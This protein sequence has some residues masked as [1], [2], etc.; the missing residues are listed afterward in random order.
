MH[1]D[2]LEQFIQDNREAFDTDLPEL[3]VWGNISQQLDRRKHRRTLL[4]RVAGVAAAVMGL[5]FCGAAL[6]GYLSAPPTGAVAVMEGL[7]GQ[8]LQREAAYQEA[9]QEKYQQLVSY[10]QAGAVRQD[11]EL[12]DEAIREL[13][14]ELATAPPGKAEDIVEQL[15]ENYQ[16]KV[17]ILERVLNRIQMADPDREP[18]ASPK[19]EPDDRIL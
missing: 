9:I 17:Y 19:P 13:R 15:L 5:L 18:T 4:W 1:R 6:G 14:Q 8:Y 2:H 10:Q 16:A 12:L 11:L 3:R 7:D